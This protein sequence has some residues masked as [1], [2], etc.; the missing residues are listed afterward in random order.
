M[1]IALAAVTTAVS[2][3]GENLDQYVTDILFPNDQRQ[4]LKVLIDAV[5]KIK[6]MVKNAE[7][8]ASDTVRREIEGKLEKC[9]NQQNNPNS[10]QYRANYSE[11]DD[12]EVMMAAS[13]MQEDTTLGVERIRSPSNY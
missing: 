3:L 13:P 12:D 8:P 7:P 4:H 9:R 11:W 10:S 6:K 2:R 5:R 1:K